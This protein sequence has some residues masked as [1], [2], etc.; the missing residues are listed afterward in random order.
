MILDQ[1]ISPEEGFRSEI[2]F[3]GEGEPE[4][5]VGSYPFK[6]TRYELRSE[7]LIGEDTCTVVVDKHTVV[8]LEDYN[9][10]PTFEEEEVMK[11]ILNKYHI[12][13]K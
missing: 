10:H 13:H 5:Y 12:C 11:S 3:A 1:A 2:E 4:T 6:I 9:D 7:E 8:G